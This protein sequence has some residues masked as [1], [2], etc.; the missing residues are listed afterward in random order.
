M[1]KNLFKRKKTETYT[2]SRLWPIG[3]TLHYANQDW[4]VE[5]SYQ[6]SFNDLTIEEYRINSG[7]SKL[8]LGKFIGSSERW[9]VSKPGKYASF[10]VNPKKD[11]LSGNTPQKISLSGTNYLLEETKS[12]NYS[13]SNNPTSSNVTSYFFWNIQKTGLLKFDK[14]N[15]FELD[16]HE[17]TIIKQSEITELIT[18]A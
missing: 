17:A 13:E 8:F 1:F 7:S 11:I 9:F 16:V 5:R 14:W 4:R 6:Y 3:S 12:G 10:E 2:G 15:D 18:N